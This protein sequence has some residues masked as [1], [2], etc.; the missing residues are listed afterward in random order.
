MYVQSHAIDE[1]NPPFNPYDRFSIS[2]RPFKSY[3]YDIGHGDVNMNKDVPSGDVYG[4]DECYRTECNTDTFRVMKA[5]SER[6]EGL[7]YCKN[8]RRCDCCIRSG[9][10][11]YE[12]KLLLQQMF[13][14]NQR[15]GIGID[16]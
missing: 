3:D 7:V 11:S 14:E 9:L 12:E 15:L 8:N 4:Q 1:I 2:K 5:V 16:K 13:Q 10:T 6:P